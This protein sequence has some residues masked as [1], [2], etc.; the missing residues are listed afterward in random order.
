M[1]GLTGPQP[2]WLEPPFH[3]TE[4]LCALD[5]AR[6]Q[7]K[8]EVKLHLLEMYLMSGNEEM[9]FALIELEPHFILLHSVLVHLF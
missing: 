9:T 3:M 4:H 7:R 2:P 6:V 8:R 5:R 1:G